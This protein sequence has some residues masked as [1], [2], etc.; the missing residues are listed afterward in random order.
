MSIEK[1]K[2]EIV[3]QII[4]QIKEVLEDPVEEKDS[5]D[6][7]GDTI[8]E[9]FQPILEK[10]KKLIGENEGKKSFIGALIKIFTILLSSRTTTLTKIKKLLRVSTKIALDVWPEQKIP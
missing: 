2:T 10:F 8:T 1:A 9:P 6:R 7:L 3:N 4:E 5:T